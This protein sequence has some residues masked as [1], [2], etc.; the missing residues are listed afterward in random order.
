MVYPTALVWVFDLENKELSAAV[1]RAY[2]NYI[3]EQCAKASK[4]IERS[5]SG[6]DSGSARG[7]RR[8]A[9]RHPKARSARRWSFP[10]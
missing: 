9:A 1:C 3:A 10:G 2:N 4:T 8:S 5:R 7:Y 6:A